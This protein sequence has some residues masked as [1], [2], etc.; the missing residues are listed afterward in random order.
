MIE[1]FNWLADKGVIIHVIAFVEVILV[2]R[3]HMVLHGR[4]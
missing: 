4:E 3:Y 2:V 1:L